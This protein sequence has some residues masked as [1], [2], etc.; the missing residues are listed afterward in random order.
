MHTLQSGVD[1]VNRTTESVIG[2][3]KR[4]RQRVRQPELCK[5]DITLFNRASLVTT[6][7]GNFGPPVQSFQEK[8]WR[9]PGSFCIV[10]SPADPALGPGSS[11]VGG[12]SRQQLTGKRA[13]LLGEMAFYPPV[14]EHSTGLA[15]NDLLIIVP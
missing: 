10:C 12:V 2:S 1:V 9:L 13:T 6:F 15:A 4:H 7:Q 8:A 14:K 5:S 11:D 3:N